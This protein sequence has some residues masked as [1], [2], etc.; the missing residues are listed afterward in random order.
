MPSGA[1][2]LLRQVS[3]GSPRA[4]VGLRIVTAV[5]AFAVAV[6]GSLAG[7]ATVI[8]TVVLVI[9]GRRKVQPP[10]VQD[11]PRL[12]SGAPSAGPPPRGRF[13]SPQARS[14]VRPHQEVSGTVANLP[15]GAE[16]WIVVL[17]TVEGTYWPQF[18]L[19]KGH[20]GGFRGKA[21]FGGRGREYTDVE[22]TLQLVMASP[23]ASARF[24]EFQG[25]SAPRGMPKLPAGVEPLDQLTV[26]RR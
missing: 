23:D 8:L 20:T 5:N 15:P 9:Q 14:K 2:E 16:A 1:P 12:T 19:P 11:M 10:S 25:K 13:L 7:V 4:P 6:V 24:R 26:T 18:N 21:R 3:A 17:P 22:Y